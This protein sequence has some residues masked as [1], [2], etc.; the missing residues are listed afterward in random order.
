MPEIELENISPEQE[1]VINVIMN[2]GRLRAYEEILRN[3]EQEHFAT[4]TEDPYYAYYIEHVMKV[5]KER[6]DELAKEVE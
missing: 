4:A 3:L 1:L 2:E 5:I 6:Y